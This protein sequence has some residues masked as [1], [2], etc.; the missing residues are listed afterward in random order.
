MFKIF[1]RPIQR[2]NMDYLMSGLLG[3]SNAIQ[4]KISTLMSQDKIQNSNGLQ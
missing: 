1:K 2:S 3:N 4:L